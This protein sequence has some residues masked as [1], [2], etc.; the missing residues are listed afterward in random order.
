MLTVVFLSIDRAT[1]VPTLIKTTFVN[2]VMAA[3]DLYSFFKR[4]KTTDK[5]SAEEETNDTDVPS[6]SGST[7][8]RPPSLTE[9]NVS[10][11]VSCSGTDT[12]AIGAG[13]SE[14]SEPQ[15]SQQPK[16]KKVNKFQ[17][18]WLTHWPWLRFEN[19]QM[20]CASCREARPHDHTAKWSDW[21]TGLISKSSVSH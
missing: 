2:R 13:V 15:Q 7:T 21:S 17:E 1:T 4:N 12:S 18:K 10:V 8:S 16:R 20:F 5:E 11:H 9:P 14:V 19:E 6:S 3:K